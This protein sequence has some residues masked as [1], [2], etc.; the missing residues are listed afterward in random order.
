MLATL[1]HDPGNAEDL[2]KLLKRMAGRVVEVPSA[3]GDRMKEETR[4]GILHWGRETGE[5]ARIEIGKLRGEIR[6][7]FG[8]G[9]PRV[10][11]PL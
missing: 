10:L 9:A 1:L 7:G 6:E 11:D 4:D 8:G 2:R 5:E 3:G